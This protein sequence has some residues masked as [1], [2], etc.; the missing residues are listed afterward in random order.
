M[1]LANQVRGYSYLSAVLANRSIDPF[2]RSCSS[3]LSTLLTVTET[4]RRFEIEHKEEIEKN[5]DGFSLTFLVAKSGINGIR[6][7]DPAVPQKKAG[8][9]KLPEGI[10]FLK[11]SLSIL[12]KI[13]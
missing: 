10:C 3:F 13:Q 9:C 2:C 8:N 7:P 6:Q 4:I 5:P 11:S 12:Q 1:D